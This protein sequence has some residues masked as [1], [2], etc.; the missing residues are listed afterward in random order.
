[1]GPLCNKY[2]NWYKIRLLFIILGAK[3]E[4]KL[5]LL[6]Y[7]EITE[8]CNL[9]CEHCYNHDFLGNGNNDLSDA[10]VLQVVDTIIKEGVFDILLTGG[11]PLVKENLIRKIVNFCQERNTFVS[12]NTNLLR[13]NS[14]MFDFLPL[15]TGL[16]ISCPSV[17]PSSYREMTGG[18][19]YSLFEQNYSQ[20]VQH[21][22]G[23]IINMVVNKRNLHEIRTVAQRMESL[24]ATF[25][26][27]TPMLYSWDAPHIKEKM[28]SLEELHFLFNELE[29]VASSTNLKV[30]IKSCLPKCAIP[31]ELFKR[32]YSFLFRGCQAGRRSVAIS[33]SGEVRACANN[34]QSYGNVLQTSL[35]EIYS[36]MTKWRDGSYIPATCKECNILSNCNAACRRQ[37]QCYYGQEMHQDPWM[38]TPFITNPYPT[39]K[40]HPNL[41]SNPNSLNASNAL[42]SSKNIDTDNEH[43]CEHGHKNEHGNENGHTGSVSLPSSGQYKFNPFIRWRKEDDKFFILYNENR[44]EAAKI[45]PPLMSFINDL[46]NSLVAPLSLYEIANKY[47]IDLADASFQNIIKQLLELEVLIKVPHYEKVL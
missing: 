7:L 46:N 8:I 10:Q 47:Q 9:R 16:L 17:V 28:L 15:T 22:I 3:M 44:C 18:G 23:N 24:G 27:A 40:R 30:D 31:K 32:N 4:Y 12:I 33:S 36:R 19:N 42:N 5:P 20:I 6:T 34:P 21:N 45:N 37:A 14:N 26:S 41:R 25:F 43:K 11:E 13:L 2:I 29:W 1:M 38:T 35:R 39:S